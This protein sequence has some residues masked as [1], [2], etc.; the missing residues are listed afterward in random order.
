[1]KPPIIEGPFLETNMIRKLLVPVVLSILLLAGCVTSQS[2]PISAQEAPVDP[3]AV[4][5]PQEVQAKVKVQLYSMSVGEDYFRIRLRIHNLSDVHTTLVQEVVLSTGETLVECFVFSPGMHIIDMHSQSGMTEK[6][7]R[8]MFIY[9]ATIEGVDLHRGV[10]G[11]LPQNKDGSLKTDIPFYFNMQ[12]Q[13]QYKTQGRVVEDNKPAGVRWSIT[14]EPGEVPK[15]T[16]RVPGKTYTCTVEDDVEPEEEPEG[17][18][19]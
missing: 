13:M 3:P 18:D 5:Q 19:Y 11:H 12:Y 14:Y 17:E 6:T 10:F 1:M 8:E 16:L 9:P 2:N 15:V 4:E 7:V